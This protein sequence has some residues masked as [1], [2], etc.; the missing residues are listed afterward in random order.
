MCALPSWLEDVAGGSGVGLGLQRG[1]L[2]EGCA[3]VLLHAGEAAGNV[4]VEGGDDGGLGHVFDLVGLGVAVWNVGVEGVLREPVLGG[5]EWFVGVGAEEVEG[6]AGLVDEDGHVVFYLVEYGDVAVR[7]V[8]VSAGRV[9][10]C[11][12]MAHPLT[13][14]DRD[15]AKVIDQVTHWGGAVFVAA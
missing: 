1:V 14:V 12:H 4:L 9:G 11:D 15:S 5:G 6:V 2:V 3:G 7:I 10:Q 13:H 8:R